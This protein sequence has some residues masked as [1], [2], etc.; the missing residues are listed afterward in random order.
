MSFSMQYRMLMIRNTVAKSPLI[1]FIFWENIDV[2]VNT[3][4]KLLRN[5]P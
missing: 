5:F 4:Q 1:F 2:F 3:L